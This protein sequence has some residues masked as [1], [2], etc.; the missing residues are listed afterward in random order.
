MTA[1][2][3]TRPRLE[4]L[5]VS[6]VDAGA[7]ADFYRAVW[8]PEAT[9]EWVLASR[10]AARL[11]N[12]AAPG[13]VPPAFAA[14]Q[15]DRVLGYVGS[16]PIRLSD[17]R[18]EWPGYW[19]KG[20]MVRPEVRNGPIGFLVLKEAV[21]HIPRSVVLTVAPASRRLFGALGYT[22]FGALPNWIRPLAGARIAVRA[23]PSRLGLDGLPAWTG[24][25]H[26]LAGRTGLLGL[27]GAVAGALLD[28]IAKASRLG[29]RYQ[30][31]RLDPEL[32]AGHLDRLWPAIRS[33]LG[34]AV[35]RDA[36][37]LLKRYVEGRGHRYLWTGAWEGDTLAGVAI[38]TRARDE[39][40]PRLQGLR[41]AALADLWFDPARPGL[42]RALLGGVEDAARRDGADAVLAT[43]AAPAAVAA[44]RWQ[45]YLPL[46]GN[47][48]FFLRDTAGGTGLAGG[49]DRWW[50]QRGDGESDAVF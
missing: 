34:S 6:Q 32:V 8:N 28:G 7:L 42:G 48:H 43:T 31:G 35:V 9:A 41:V 1:P 15:G 22:D 4:V 49:L 37:Y 5:S 23:D 46:P 36:R 17:G 2:A 33:R 30:T 16:I 19:I 40:D 12:E 29:G 18:Q 20:L 14:V 38:A 45:G 25:V 50:L 21:R 10:E 13:V 47:V 39:T 3:T 26:R 11:G 27:G 44:L 24:S